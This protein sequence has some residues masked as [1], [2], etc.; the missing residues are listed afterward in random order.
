MGG[1]Q[2]RRA[3]R[4]REK[5][6]KRGAGSA[7]RPRGQ[8]GSG[9]RGQ[10]QHRALVAEAGWRTGEGGGARVTRRSV[11]DRW[12]RAA[13]GPDVSSGVWEGEG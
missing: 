1:G 6:R 3:T 12:G 5:E 4:R 10:R 2:L 11:A 9:R 8:N 13:T 7:A